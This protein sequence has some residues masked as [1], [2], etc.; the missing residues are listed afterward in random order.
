MSCKM[1]HFSRK[2]CI[3]N[4]VAHP[5]HPAAMTPTVGTPSTSPLPTFKVV[6]ALPRAEYSVA[7]ISEVPTAVESCNVL[8]RDVDAGL[9]GGKL[10]MVT[11]NS[12]RLQYLLALLHYLQQ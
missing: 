1:I 7:R 6:N 10:Q 4:A 8:R 12:E 3:E 11:K 9:P 5:G 2:H